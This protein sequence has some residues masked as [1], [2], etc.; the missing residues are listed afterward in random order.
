MLVA[1]A[2]VFFGAWLFFTGWLKDR[3]KS[4]LAMILFFLN[5]GFGFAYFLSDL[6]ESYDNFTRIFTA[7][8]ETPTNLIGENI[9]WVN[10][11]V[12]M[13]VPQRA[14][15]FGWAILFPLLYVLYRAVYAQKHAYFLPAAIFAGSMVMIHTHSF[16]A[17]GLICGVWLLFVLLKTAGLYRIAVLHTAK[18]VTALLFIIPAA[19]GLAA[20]RVIPRESVLWLILAVC[21]AVVF[22]SP[23]ERAAGKCCFPH[24]AYFSAS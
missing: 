2:Q 16:L 14:T 4:I 5:G 13:M 19:A 15:L 10:V 11:I 22:R 9:R 8:Y 3:A 20:V 24:G 6:G 1:G 23:S 7:F 21:A 12:D 17:L 18:R